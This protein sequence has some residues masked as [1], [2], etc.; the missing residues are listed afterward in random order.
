[1]ADMN[2]PTPEWLK[3]L[4]EERGLSDTPSGD[5]GDAMTNLEDL[6][7]NIEI[8]PKGWAH[9]K[10]LIVGD[11]SVDRIEIFRRVTEMSEDDMLM[12]MALIAI[13]YGLARAM[14][15]SEK[16]SERLISY[17]AASYVISMARGYDLGQKD[18][19]DERQT[20]DE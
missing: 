12:F 10:Q 4:T 11:K 14:G 2:T 7:K 1:M 15:Y 18:S 16:H 8:T 9:V 19:Q 17:F 5:E 20:R 6:V 13:P 3:E